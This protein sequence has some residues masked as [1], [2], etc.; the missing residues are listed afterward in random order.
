MDEKEFINLFAVAQT[1]SAKA[2]C[3]CIKTVLFKIISFGYFKNAK[4]NAV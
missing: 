3:T 1:H 4:L 2:N